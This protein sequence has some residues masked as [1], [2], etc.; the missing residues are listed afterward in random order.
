MLH[1]NATSK[2]HHDSLK[3]NMS[4]SKRILWKL[5]VCFITT[6]I[7]SIHVIIRLLG[8]F[9]TKQMQIKAANSTIDAYKVS[10]AM[11]AQYVATIVRL[12]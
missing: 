4:E 5:C 1:E 10:C 3:L 6:H 11:S 8:A 7:C 9:V 12:Q 2:T